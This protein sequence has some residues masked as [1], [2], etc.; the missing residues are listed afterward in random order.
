MAREVGVPFY[1]LAVEN[2]ET[3]HKEGDLVVVSDHVAV[4][5]YAAPEGRIFDFSRE[6]QLDEKN[7]RRIS[8]ITA[9]AMFYTNRGAEALQD[10]DVEESLRWFKAAVLLDPELAH[11]WVNLGVGLRRIG[12]TRGAEDA[13]QKGLEVDPRLP[14]A[15]QNLVALLAVLGR[16]EEAREYQRALQKSPSRNPYSYLTLGD[17]SRRSG[18]LAE[19]RLVTATPAGSRLPPIRLRLATTRG[20]NALLERRGAAT[21]LFI[22]RGFGDLL[23]IGNQQRVA[24]FALDVRRA[25]ALYREVVEVPERLAAN[26][27]VIEPLDL[28]AVLPEVERLLGSGIESTAAALLHSY[29]NPAHEQAVAAELRR[30][31]LRSVSTSAE[32]AS[33]VKILPRAE[34]A[35]V[36]AY[37]APIIESYLADVAGA[38]D[39]CDPGSSSLHMMT[40]AGGLV[41]AERYQARDSL[42]SGPAGGVVRAVR[43]GREN[44]VRRLIAF[45]MGG[46]STDAS[47][48]D[49]DYEYLYEHRVGSAT[50]AAP[51]LAIET[52]AAGGGSI[53]WLAGDPAGPGSG[54][55]RQVKVGPES[56]G[57][58]PGP[59]CYGA[60][61]PLTLTDVNLLLGRLDPRRF[62]IPIVRPAAEA[63]LGDLV[64]GLA[65]RGDGMTREALLQGFLDVAN[66]RMA[67]AVRRISVRRG[68]DPRD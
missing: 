39:G 1:F 59:A 42:L 15:Y 52:V 48:F 46:T 63:A 43:S 31:G 9:I 47:R 29:R 36:N 51:A 40:S 38:L 34:T 44:G 58:D 54:G 13:Y 49:G 30:Q 6:G 28:A 4:G 41:R 3:Y 8:D 67:D 18:R 22:T 64:A 11:A 56:A 17:I 55:A 21:A 12:D 61:G 25:P 60:G 19:A 23:R 35:V 68:Y 53:C 65:G 14:S 33:V 50:V 62:G 16:E 45:D 2:I 7:V 27:T 24:L 66:E 20:T 26:G 37:L 5:F 57:A 32:L 10:G